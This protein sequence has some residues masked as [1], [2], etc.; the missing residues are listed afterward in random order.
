MLWYNVSF[1]QH[2]VRVVAAVAE[3]RY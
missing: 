1:K 3:V 2:L